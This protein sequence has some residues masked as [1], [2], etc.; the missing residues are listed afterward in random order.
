MTIEVSHDR[1][2]VKIANNLNNDYLIREVLYL[3]RNLFWG[4]CSKDC[5]EMNSEVSKRDGMVS[6]N[7]MNLK[8]SS[9]GKWMNGLNILLKEINSDTIRKHCKI[10]FTFIYQVKGIYIVT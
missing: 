7:L 10:N 8:K 6:K 1:K 9:K 4:C 5:V 3:G 2:A